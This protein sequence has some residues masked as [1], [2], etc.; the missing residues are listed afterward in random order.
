MDEWFLEIEVNLIVGL[1]VRVHASALGVDRSA[2]F[3]VLELGAVLEN[4]GVFKGD[5]AGIAAFR[6]FTESLS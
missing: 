6:R 1:V 5:E 2:D 3:L 4:A